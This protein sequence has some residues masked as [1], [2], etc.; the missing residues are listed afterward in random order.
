MWACF[1]QK[2]MRKSH[3]GPTD[4]RVPAD[5]PD[6]PIATVESTAMFGAAIFGRETIPNPDDGETCSRVRVA[7]RVA[8]VMLDATVGSNAN[9]FFIACALAAQRASEKENER[10]VSKAGTEEA[11][12]L[13]PH[14]F[15]LLFNPM[16]LSR[17]TTGDCST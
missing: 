15:F 16:R 10:T 14:P 12:M 9:A 2:K 4:G 3:T 8:K 6:Y 11:T 7:L 13:N 17:W 1:R 5:V